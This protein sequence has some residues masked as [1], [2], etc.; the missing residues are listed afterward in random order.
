MENK[1]L[2]KS[3][4]EFFEE[5]L[6]LGNGSFGGMVY[7]NISN[8]K[9]SLNLDSFWNGTPNPDNKPDKRK[10]FERVKELIK[11]GKHQETDKYVVDNIA[12]KQST[13]YLPVGNLFIENDGCYEGEYTRFLDLEKSLAVTEISDSVRYEY[14]FSY[15]HKCG[16]I[17]IV[18]SVPTTIKIHFTS[19][20][21]NEISYRDGVLMM[22]GAAA[23]HH[24][25]EINEGSLDDGYKSVKFV[26]TLGFDCDGVADYSDGKV[27]FENITR[28]TLFLTGNTTFINHR[29][30]STLKTCEEKTL[31]Q[32][33]N[34]KKAGYELI[35]QNHT[36][37][38]TKL[39]NITTLDF[40]GKQNN[41]DTKSRIESGVFDVG[42]CEL[43]FNY[44]KYL[45]IACSRKGSL[46]SNLQGIWNEHEKAPWCSN[47]TVNINTEMNYWP[48]LML[49]L[50]SCYM[51]L[52]DLVKKI[53]DTGRSEAKSLYE[54]GGFVCHHNSD[55]WGYTET[56]GN[57]S[58]SACYC[59]WSGA[60]GWLS[61]MLFEYYEY[62]LDTD[63]LE[64]VALPIM[65]Q[66]AVF[67]LDIL[68]EHDGKLVISPAT[69]PE[70][71]FLID[72]VVCSSAMYSQMSQSICADLFK[73]VIK[74]LEITGT[75]KEFKKKLED[76]LEKVEFYEISEDNR[77]I[78]WDKAYKYND[79][80]HRH[81]SHL[82]CMFPGELITTQNNPDV[83]S[84]IRTSLEARGMGGTGW[85]LGWK[86]NLWAKLKDS[87]KAFYFVK[88]LLTPVSPD[89]TM[90]CSKGAGVYPNLF[91]AH[92]PF[93]ID[94]NFGV[95]SGI[96]LM[97]VQKEDGIIQI[98]PA[99]PDELACG[100]LCGLKLKGGISLDMQ[101]EDKKAVSVYLTAL[102]DTTE[103]V[104]IND[105]I[106]EVSLKEGQKKRLIFN[107]L[108]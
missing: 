22:K 6:P 96:A 54:A 66:A 85:S 81:V 57:Y 2:Y 15:P 86:T 71:S 68:V 80:L 32:L 106:I 1:L 98:L 78:E 58:T 107:K 10:H 72:D 83:A 59:L 11:E 20:V 31:S 30:L 25:S 38:V 5:A 94:G 69:S 36:D 9:I 19:L 26:V 23:D 47:Y 52:V 88:A 91:D 45:T 77:L 3:C 7:G 103:K 14:F 37:D 49:G 75:D 29:T 82:Y 42:L 34:V 16:C 35:K 105:R 95:T 84:A 50:D 33:E 46:A 108:L 39:Y 76:V 65:K 12:R 27:C 28:L 97:L 90:S 41:A 93:Q 101:W 4:A 73:A 62:T 87:E 24:P 48:T 102:K 13:C 40:N 89:T 99:L 17:N 63:Y 8:E 43:L 56:T 100:K 60:S 74:A 61:K 51:P 18:S 67:Y 44:G 92:P 21:A 104:K 79:E 53:S 64:Y 55:L 70:N